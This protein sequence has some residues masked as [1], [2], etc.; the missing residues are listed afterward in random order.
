MSDMFITLS[1]LH[2]S[3]FYI[4]Y[5]STYLFIC[6]LYYNPAH[7]VDYIASNNRIIRE[8]GEGGKKR[9]KRGRRDRRRGG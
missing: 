5:L 3:Y 8:M 6:N 9:M 1:E 7:S 4:V 2:A